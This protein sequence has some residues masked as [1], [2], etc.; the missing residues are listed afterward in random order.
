MTE[1]ITL[2]TYLAGWAAV[3]AEMASAAAVVRAI[4]D[5]CA[6][7]AHRIAC[8]PLVD[9]LSAAAGGEEQK[10]LDVWAQDRLNDALRAV[11][12]AAILSEECAT[13]MHLSAAGNVAVALDPLD[14]SSNIET[15]IPM[16]S[17]FSIL[18]AN[19]MAGTDAIFMQPG[20]AQI[21]AGYVIYGPQTALVLTAG[22]G[23]QMFTLDPL[24]R[25]FWLTV[26]RMNIK[27]MSDQ[28]AINASNYRHWSDSVRAY[29]DDCI[30]GTEGPR[31]SDVNMR[32][33]ASLVAECHRILV[34]GGVFLYPADARKGYEKGRL[35]L[36]YEANPIAF[37]AEQAGGQAT[38]GHT[39]IMD[40]V[41]ASMHE[42]T[43]L[44]FGSADEID[45]IIRYKADPNALFSR[46]P[47]FKKRGLLRV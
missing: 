4:A 26:P 38:N 32:W 24:T 15:N 12:V 42:R 40:I 27:R 46:S 13:P 31:G 23:T 36:V 33:I 3:S 20:S 14:A 21:A 28:Y 41:P 44:I 7:I 17:V 5:A 16:G 39:R 8:G 2:E 45:R 37:I 34:R 11:P 18:P 6:D 29:I 1:Q 47:L 10:D 9:D 30:A 43:P 25:Q 19:G 22:Q 35:R